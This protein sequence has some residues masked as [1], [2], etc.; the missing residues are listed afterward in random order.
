[1]EQYFNLKL[2]K[3]VQK[4]QQQV[5]E[6]TKMH[7]STF[8]ARFKVR[9]KIKRIFRQISHWIR[10]N[11]KFVKYTPSVKLRVYFTQQRDN[12]SSNAKHGTINA[13]MCFPLGLIR[14]RATR[15]YYLSSCC[16][17]AEIL[18]G[19]YGSRKSIIYYDFDFSILF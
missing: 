5:I 7:C 4:G 16:E 12:A 19:I 2:R 18:R 3:R 14:S 6:Q 17:E 8:Q 11:F 9:S 1:M 15:F 10:R 13:K